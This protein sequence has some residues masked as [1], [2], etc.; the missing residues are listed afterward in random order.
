MAE[1]EVRVVRVQLP[2]ELAA[3]YYVRV[4]VGLSLGV[5]PD[6]EID[7]KSDEPV[8]HL[9]V[10]DGHEPVAAGRWR[11]YE[12]QA[13]FERI[14]VVPSRRGQGWGRR[15]M[16]ALEAE[17]RAAGKTKAVLTART[18]VEQ[19]YQSLGYTAGEAV[20]GP[21]HFPLR[22]YRKDLADHSHP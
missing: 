20:P 3:A 5:G 11:D 1:P 13:K 22:W 10:L 8:R 19:F 18:E 17:A 2:W 16:E 14:G 4:T 7:E 15:I 21:T 6:R 9:V 12:D